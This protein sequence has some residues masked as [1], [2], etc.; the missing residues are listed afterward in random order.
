MSVA[1]LPKTE[2]SA[3]T[4]PND[5]GLLLDSL[6]IKNFRAFRHLT[7]EKLGRVN[8]ITGKNGVGKTSLLEALRV[9]ADNATPSV[10][11][12]IADE[13]RELTR[14]PGT[15][16]VDKRED[17]AIVDAG[18]L[19][20][21]RTG[22]WNERQFSIGAINDDRR[23]VHLEYAPADPFSGLDDKINV[24]GPD[25]YSYNASLLANQRKALA[26][27]S[28]YGTIAHRAV[29]SGLRGVNELATA[30]DNIVLTSEEDNVIQALRLIDEQI[31]RISFV[32]FDLEGALLRVA[33]VKRE[34]EDRPVPL[35][36]LG[37]GIN[38]LFAIAIALAG[39]SSGLAL[40]DEIENGLHYSVLPDIWE[41]I[42]NTASRLDIQ[43]FA[44]THS[45]GCIEAFTQVASE[46]GNLQSGR[47]IQ[48]RNK[49]KNVVATIHDEEDL[50]IIVRSGIEVR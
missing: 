35:E 46:D 44:T 10:I 17:G 36:S 43:V 9:Y 11:R 29:K 22:K 2:E 16:L 15:M 42:F 18:F 1:E 24:Y 4:R 13:R 14:P 23:Q 40:F 33:M 48:L 3:P 12:Q 37:E 7:I 21:G 31:E 45:W 50:K 28:R 38:R 30:W 8:L 19:F 27:G 49:N 20:H 6:E 47:L 25:E 32:S 5:G 41:L 34:G 26:S 39:A